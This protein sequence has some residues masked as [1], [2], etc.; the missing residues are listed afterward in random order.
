MIDSGLVGSGE[1]TQDKKMSR[2]H[3]PR[4]VYHQ[5]YKIREGGYEVASVEK[6]AV[7]PVPQLAV[8]VY[9]SPAVAACQHGGDVRSENPLP[10]HINSSRR[11]VRDAWDLAGWR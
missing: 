1:V 8:M 11:G 6:T 4:V 3:L 7:K 10:N 2:F 9:P 5:V